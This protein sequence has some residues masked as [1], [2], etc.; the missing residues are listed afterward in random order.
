MKRSLLQLVLSGFMLVLSVVAFGQGTTTSSLNGR[1]TDA[2]G[3]PLP[4]ATIVAIHTPSGSQYGNISNSDGFYRIPNM[5][6]G[7]PY[8]VTISFVGFQAV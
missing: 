8:T 7:G 5:R 2:S 6:V 1:V 4:G 3:E